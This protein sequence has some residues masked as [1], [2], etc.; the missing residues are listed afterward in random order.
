M[1]KSS[2]KLLRPKRIND[3]FNVKSRMNLND[4]VCQ[5]ILEQEAWQNT[6]SLRNQRNCQLSLQL[7]LISPG[8]AWITSCK[9]TG[10]CN[11]YQH[12][13]TVYIML[14]IFLSFSDLRVRNW[15]WGPSHYS[16]CEKLYNC[17]DRIPQMWLYWLSFIIYVM[18]KSN[19]LVLI[20]TKFRYFDPSDISAHNM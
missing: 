13:R 6:C 17:F 7:W 12:C 10:L 1:S 2:G 15:G 20:Y 16:V 9:I 19:M 18:R 5:S 14:F 11:Y 3:N 4:T 8:E